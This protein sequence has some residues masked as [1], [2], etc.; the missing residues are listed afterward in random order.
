MI[1]LSQITNQYFYQFSSV[2]QL[3]LT[4]CDPMNCSTPGFP[5]LHH[6]LE[7]AQIHV[8]W[9]SDA[10]QPSR[11]LSCPS[12][13]AFNLSQ[14]QG[15]FLMNQLFTLGGQSIGAS[16][17]ASV[18]P[19]NIQSWFPLG[20]TGWISLQ[21]KGLSKVF[22]ST[23]IQKHQFSST[24]TSLCSNSHICIWLLEKP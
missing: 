16:A 18:L 4:F 15:L 3:C 9:V 24:Q 22:S 8:H 2:I 10:I 5:V 19:M 13:P 7:F 6:L 1:Y 20:W 21:S 14:H 23:T 11:L 12:P 17:S